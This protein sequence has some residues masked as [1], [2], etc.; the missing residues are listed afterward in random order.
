MVPVHDAL[1]RMGLME[2]VKGKTGLLFPE[3]R[4]DSRH[5]T[6]TAALSE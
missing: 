1:V 5:G 4:P 2:R 3:L 6:Y